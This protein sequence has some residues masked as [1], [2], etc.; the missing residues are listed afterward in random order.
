MRIENSNV[1]GIT[2]IDGNGIIVINGKKV[3]IPKHVSSAKVLSNTTI[4]NDKVFINGY[5]LKKDGTWKKTL[6][7]LW[8]KWF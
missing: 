4:I 2:Q 7:A 6:L 5:E 8:H 3:E 1:G